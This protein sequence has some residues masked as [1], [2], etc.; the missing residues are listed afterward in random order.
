MFAI[1]IFVFS[2]IVVALLLLIKRWEIRNGKTGF[3]LRAISRSE[4]G[5]QELQDRFL[6]M[7]LDS[8]EIVSLWVRKH[9][10]FKA[11]SLKNRTLAWSK[12]SAKK[13]MGDLRDSR[14]LKKRED[15][16]SEFFKNIS[17]IEKGNGKIHDDEYREDEMETKEAVVTKVEEGPKSK[18]KG[19]YT[20]RKKTV[21]L[22]VVEEK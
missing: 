19:K 11:R 22:E 15:G 6:A 4:E 1:Y 5:F 7:Y 21:R 3:V 18:P 8:K 12:E 20:S 16:M 2:G 13:V 10:P 17:D 14:L 9:L